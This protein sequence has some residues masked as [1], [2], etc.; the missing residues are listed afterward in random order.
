M[1]RITFVVTGRVQGVGFRASAASAAQRLS[2]TGFVRNRPDGAVEGQA[3]GDVG[4]I[5]AFV[6]WL[7][8]GPRFA[9]VANLDVQD[10]PLGEGERDFE[11]RR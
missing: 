6:A 3:Q 9:A 8:R 4:A 2:V 1:R 11:V 5:A 10:V 7:Q